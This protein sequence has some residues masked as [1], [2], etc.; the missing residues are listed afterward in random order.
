V[1]KASRGWDNAK[2][3]NGRKRHITV[4]TTGLLLEVLITSASVQDRD[5]SHT[6]RAGQ[7]VYW[8]GFEVITFSPAAQDLSPCR[9]GMAAGRLLIGPQ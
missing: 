4:D 1:P 2:K 7:A 8:Q 5:A 9:P 3:V 6:D